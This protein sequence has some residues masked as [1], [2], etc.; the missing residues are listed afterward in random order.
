MLNYYRIAGRIVQMDSF[1]R[2]EAQALP[3]RINDN[4]NPDIIV[5]SEFERARKDFKSLSDS[6]VEY[7][8]TGANFYKQ[9]LNFDG[10]MLHSSA[11]VM[12]GMAY[13][14]TADSGGGKSTH[15]SLWRQ[16]FGDEHVRMLND[17]KPALCYEDGKWFSYGTPWCGKTGQNANLRVPIAGIAVIEKHTHNCI[18]RFTGLEAVVTLLRQANKPNDAVSRGKMMQLVDMLL[19][20]IPV[21]K[22][23]CNMDPEAAIVSYEAMSGRKF[24]GR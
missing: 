17:D 18:E 10:F 9:L 19:K 13:L 14:F 23:K 15:T 8:A 20:D 16:V 22:M 4:K 6:D 7:I 11:V 2:T 21:W 12:D 3:Y 1:G 5:A 24:E